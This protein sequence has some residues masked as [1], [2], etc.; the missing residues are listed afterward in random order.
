MHLYVA[1]VLSNH[2]IICDA[3]EIRLY[4]IKIIYISFSYHLRSMISFRSHFNHISVIK[5]PAFM[6]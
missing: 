3:V 6:E 2:K 5:E 4:Y 1:I